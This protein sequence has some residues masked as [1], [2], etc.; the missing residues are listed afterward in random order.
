[1]DV[2]Q[3]LETRYTFSF[4]ALHQLYATCGQSNSDLRYNKQNGSTLLNEERNPPYSYTNMYYNAGKAVY[5]LWQKQKLNVTFRCHQQLIFIM[6][7]IY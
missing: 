4:R 1:M 3:G 2:V 5:I 7:T 6:L